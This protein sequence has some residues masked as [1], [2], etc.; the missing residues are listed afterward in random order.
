[1]NFKFLFIQ[2]ILCLGAFQAI[3][4][5]KCDDFNAEVVFIGCAPD[6]WVGIQVTGGSGAYSTFDGSE[7]PPGSGYF[8]EV[9]LDAGTYTF[10]FRDSNGCQT[11]VTFTIL[12]KECCE[13]DL[14]AAVI[15]SGCAPNGWVQIQV[16][17]GTPPYSSNDAFP[18]GGG[19][20]QDGGLNAGTYT[21]TFEDGN[22]CQTDVTFEIISGE[23]CNSDLDAEVIYIGCAPEGWVGI[24]VTG[25]SGDYSS[26]FGSE[27]PPGSGYFEEVELDAG[28]YTATYYDSNGCEV[29]VTFTILSKECCDSDL[30]AEVINTSCGPNGT[31]QIQVSGGTRPYSST[32]ANHVGG[33][34][35]QAIGLDEGTY[36]YT[37]EDSNGC[38]TDVSFTI[39]DECCDFMA[40]V[41]YIGC[42]PDGW[43]G[44]QVTGGSG[45]YNSFFGSEEPP[46]SGYFEEVE[47]DAG[48]YTATYYDSNGCQ[49]DVTFTIQS[50]ECCGPD[51]VAEVIN[52]GC[53]PEGW[54]GI[55]VSGGSGEYGSYDGSEEPPGSGYFEDDGLDIGTYTYTYWDSNGCETD[56]TFTIGNECCDFEASVIKGGCGPDG[57]VGIQVTGG[58]G[59]Y[60]SADGINEEPS[61]SGY[62]E[63]VEL[64][65]GTYTYTFT[66]SNGCQ[67]DVTFT[68]GDECCDYCNAFT[69]VVAGISTGG[70]FPNLPPSAGT[71]PITLI[72]QFD[73]TI[74]TQFQAKAVPDRYVITVNGVDVLDKTL[75]SCPGADCT[76]D[77][78]TG[79]I[80]LD[81]FCVAKCD[82]VVFTFYGDWC[83]QTC[84]NNHPPTA[85]RFDVIGCSIKDSDGG[86]SLVG[87]TEIENRSRILIE[88][89]LT[90]KVE[91]SSTVVSDVLSVNILN[92]SSM[93]D[94]YI[95]SEVNQFSMLRIISNTGTPLI[96][97]N[98]SDKN[99]IKL[100]VNSISP[101]IYF[102]ELSNDKGNTIIEKFVKI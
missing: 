19:I 44:I 22:G 30:D 5:E 53:G 71:G 42:A 17:G 48:T 79:A 74:Y 21:Y 84:L 8:E 87:T 65:L 14:G 31:V 75:S 2:L 38:Q 97:K 25:G 9:D 77:V 45:D 52:S 72:S 92:T 98:I 61:G 11:D 68:I 62:F 32:D 55:Q 66:D 96:T 76:G 101:G 99:Q 70:E 85:W 24:Q 81:T 12:S 18:V 26:F 54:V 35:F 7:E 29:D 86:S 80:L 23:C 88:E 63:E 59:V 94:Q 16:T 28:T 36:T 6:G 34:V 20:F 83:S 95:E 90:Q 57:W 50:K 102:L 4:Q 37:F 13:S 39:E 15:N 93:V 64:D 56:V 41:I 43:V 51:L 47:L 49:I 58:S 60:T 10:T 78:T 67:T 33:G 1:M 46:G 3:S 69:N 89:S 100:D 27:E 73:A 40:E 91:I 82:E